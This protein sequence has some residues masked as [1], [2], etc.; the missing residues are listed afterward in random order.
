MQ[1]Y[2]SM[3]DTLGSKGYEHVVPHLVRVQKFLVDANYSVSPINEIHPDRTCSTCRVPIPL[4]HMVLKP[5]EPPSGVM[6]WE[7]AEAGFLSVEPDAVA[8]PALDQFRDRGDR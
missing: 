6:C 7:C 2:F 1:N 5:L 8:P 4:G 3:L